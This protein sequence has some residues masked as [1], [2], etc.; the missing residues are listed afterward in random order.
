MRGL[1]QLESIK[2]RSVRRNRFTVIR[3]LLSA[4]LI[5]GMIYLVDP[6]KVWISFSGMELWPLIIACVLFALGQVLTALRWQRVL[7]SLRDKPPG[8]WYLNGLYHVGMFFNFFLPSTM[9][10]DVVRAEMAKSFSGGRAESY[11]AVLFDR[12]S[13][14]I[15]VVLIGAIALVF[16]YVGIGWFDWQVGLLSL[17]FI[18]IAVM[19]FVVLETS[20]A[21]RI[22]KLLKRGRLIKLIA[23][24]Q[25]SLAL[26][27]GFAANK[28][29]LFHIVGLALFIQAVSILVIYF[30]GLSLG[31]DVGVLFHFVAI[32][33]VILVTLGAVAV[34]GLGVREVAFVLLYS[35]VG[36]PSEMALALSF[37]WTLLLVLFSFFGGLCL[38]FPSMYRFIEDR[39]AEH[40]PQIEWNSK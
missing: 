24:I 9:G 14:F 5:V 29:M 6:Q 27:Q 12:F 17:L 33:I 35:K 37:S 19:V 3:F 4:G 10:G 40:A 25:N 21:D 7:R 1:N 2:N 34:N 18:I 20:L 32:P 31:I 28:P 38:Q 11:T 36:V 16:S 23:I 13:A 30:L 39:T 8:I 15:A 26:L 22:L